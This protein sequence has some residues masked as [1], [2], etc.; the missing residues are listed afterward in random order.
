ML[1]EREINWLSEH[2]F[3]AGQANILEVGSANGNYGSYL[4]RKFSK[5]EIYGLEANPHLTARLSPPL[6]CPENYGIDVCVV[7]NDPIPSHISGN[8]SQCILRFVLQHVSNPVHL[9]RIIYDELPPGGRLVIIEEDDD[10]FTSHP[11]WEPLET[12][13]DIWRRVISAGGSNS[14]IGRELP[15]LATAAGFNVDVFDLNLRNNIEAGVGFRDLFTNVVRM[16]Q[17]TNPKIVTE[18][19]VKTVAEGLSSAFSENSQVLATYPQP[20]LKRS[21]YCLAPTPHFGRGILTFTWGCMFRADA[22]HKETCKTE[23]KSASKN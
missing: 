6:D 15:D 2:G 16:F 7:G 19:E 21:A 20:L 9:L 3:G 1:A 17:R 8:F 13:F 23:P 10:F 14:K 5:K 12:A 4:A 18:E 22:L 11:G